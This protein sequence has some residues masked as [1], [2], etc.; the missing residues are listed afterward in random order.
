MGY[1]PE[2]EKLIA[3]LN[4][5]ERGERLDAASSLGRLI[6]GGSI[7]RRATQE[8]N[9]HI[10]TSY[11]FSPYSP[12]AAAFRAWEAGL[13]A[14]GS[15]DHDSISAAPEIIEAGKAI[16]IATTVGVEL[17][18]HMNGT[19]IEGRRINNP[20]SENIIY[21]AIHGVPHQHIGEFEEFLK[22]IRQERNLRNRAQLE[23]LNSILEDV[24]LPLLDFEGDI[25]P[26]SMSSENGSITERHLLYGLSKMILQQVARGGELI[27]F[28]KNRL[29]IEIPPRIQDLLMDE[30]SP[31]Y[32]YDL[33]GVFKSSFLPKFFIQPNEK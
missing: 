5:R 26:L 16:G 6:E 20:D 32:A 23:A 4:A 7:S 8:V 19:A 11:S 12:S 18:V 28:L 30:N 13:L 15:M 29:K 9:N 27:A 31:H 10:H 24:S 22:P 1:P 25:L 21:M 14:V 3:S 2:I 17:R 33:L